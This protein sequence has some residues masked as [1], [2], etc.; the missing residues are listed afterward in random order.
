MQPELCL[1]HYTSPTQP[2]ELL[3]IDRYQPNDI[4]LDSS[5][6]VSI[7]V[8]HVSKEGLQINSQLGFMSPKQS[9]GQHFLSRHGDKTQQQEKTNNHNHVV[10]PKPITTFFRHGTKPTTTTF[11]RNGVQ[12]P[13]NPFPFLS[14]QP[15][16]RPSC[17]QSVSPWTPGFWSSLPSKQINS[18]SSCYC[19]RLRQIPPLVP[20]QMI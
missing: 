12:D 9:T 20:S 15:L 1:H 14:K 16:M 3:R 2:R 6:V 7:P 8:A 10:S 4:C 17:V 13:Y 5:V 19:P 18:H 11:S